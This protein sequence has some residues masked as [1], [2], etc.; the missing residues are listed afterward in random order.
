M[1][2]RDL[3]GYDWKVIVDPTRCANDPGLF[4]GGLFRMVDLRLDRDERSSWP[5]GIVFEHI[6]TCQRLTFEH[7]KLFDLTNARSLTKKPRI[8]NRKGK[9]LAQ[10]SKSTPTTIRMRRFLLIREKDLSGIS[11]TGAICESSVEAFFGHMLSFFY[12]SV[13]YQSFTF[14][15]HQTLH[16]I[17]SVCFLS[18]T[19]LSVSLY[20]KGLFQ[21]LDGLP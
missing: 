21:G 13:L 4:F 6:Q 7:G 20:R 18:L 1:S 17:L 9:S 15:P 8:R 10:K 3:N 2:R 16:L 5:D 12:I 11:G 19:K 14:L